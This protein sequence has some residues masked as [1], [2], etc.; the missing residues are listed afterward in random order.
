VLLAY[1]IGYP[2]DYCPGPS[3]LGQKLN[4]FHQY[5]VD[6]AILH[7]A[8]SN[9]HSRLMQP[10]YYL[11]DTCFLSNTHRLMQRFLFNTKIDAAFK[12][13]YDACFLSNTEIDAAFILSFVWLLSQKVLHPFCSVPPIVAA[14]FHHHLTLVLFCVTICLKQLQVCL[15]AG[16]TGTI[17]RA[18]NDYV[19]EH[20]VCL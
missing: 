6:M 16:R 19:I 9:V 4:V 5:K 7:Q 3:Q 11:D 8:S 20:C 2:P 12:L 14:N 13:L 15:S 17:F 10:S 1:F 18:M